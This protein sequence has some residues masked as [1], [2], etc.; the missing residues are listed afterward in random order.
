MPDS[1][2]TEGQVAIEFSTVHSLPRLVKYLISPQFDSVPSNDKYNL[3]YDGCKD[4][5]EREGT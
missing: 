2:L 4:D 5:I 3:E 1:F